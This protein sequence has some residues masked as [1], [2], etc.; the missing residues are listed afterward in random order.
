MIEAADK[1][2]VTLMPSLTFHFTPNYVKAKELI[3][4]GS[5]GNHLDADVS[6]VHS[7]PRTWPAS[8]R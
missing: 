6:R 3:D 1:A 7:R 8:G 2:G 4:Q 5:A